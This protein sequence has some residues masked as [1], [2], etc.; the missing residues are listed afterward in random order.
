MKYVSRKCHFWEY[1]KVL[2]PKVEWGINSG[3][4]KGSRQGCSH[5]AS[6]LSF[7]KIQYI[8]ERKKQRGQGALGA[9]FR[10]ILLSR[11]FSNF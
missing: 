3:L 10:P 8:V 6:I 11:I 4:L 5:A 7:L 1:L 2:L 9:S